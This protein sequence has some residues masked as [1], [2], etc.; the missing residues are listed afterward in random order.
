[1]SYY[2]PYLFKNVIK[3]ISINK[4]IKKVEAINFFYKNKLNKKAK[5]AIT[6]LNP[7]CDN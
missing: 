2:Y 5:F 7:H 6:G 3:N 4:I 1:M